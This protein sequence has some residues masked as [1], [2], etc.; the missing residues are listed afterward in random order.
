MSDQR[1]G[2]SA[3]SLRVMEGSIESGGEVGLAWSEENRAGRRSSPN[4]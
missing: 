4:L 3:L 2:R 1:V